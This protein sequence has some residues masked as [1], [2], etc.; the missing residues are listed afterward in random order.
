MMCGALQRPGALAAASRTGLPV[1]LMHMQGQPDNMQ[2]SPSYNDVVGEVCAFLEQRIEACEVNGIP[3]SNVIV[4][5]GFGFGKS[6]Q[7]NLALLAQ[8]QQLQVLGRPVLA[9]LSRKA[10]IGRL[11]GDDSLDRT[12]ASVCLAVLAVERGASIVRVHDVLETARAMRMVSAVRGK[13]QQ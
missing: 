10:M 3:R 2:N 8:L 4:D 5:P 11:L 6:L 13:P 12:T 9:G 7:H 1:C